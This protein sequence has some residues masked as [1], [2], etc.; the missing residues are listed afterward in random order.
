VAVEGR[1]PCQYTRMTSADDDDDDLAA[2]AGGLLTALAGGTNAT[3]AALAALRPAAATADAAAAA[4]GANGGQNGNQQQGQQGQQQQQG[5]EGGDDGGNAEGQRKRQR[6]VEHLPPA[7]GTEDVYTLL[8]LYSVSKE[9][10]RGRGKRGRGSIAFVLLSKG[11]ILHL[12]MSV[13]VKIDAI[14]ESCNQP[15]DEPL[16]PGRNRSR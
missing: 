1:L 3:A 12:R 13:F 4:A 8:K 5:G 6:T 10:V 9:L 7:N 15:T 16:E 14:R 11:P 2:A